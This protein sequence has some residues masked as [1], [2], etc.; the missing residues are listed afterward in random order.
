[1]A[2]GKGSAT[3]NN[4]TRRALESITRSDAARS[5]DAGRNSPSKITFTG[6]FAC[7]RS[8]REVVRA[9]PL[10]RRVLR[11]LPELGDLRTEYICHY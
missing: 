7:N 2:H 8:G 5:F 10:A 9:A 6:Q 11:V 3:T 1:M 4:L